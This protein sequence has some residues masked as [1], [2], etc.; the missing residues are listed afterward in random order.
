LGLPLVIGFE[1]KHIG[2]PAAEG[3]KIGVALGAERKKIIT[4]GYA[5]GYKAAVFEGINILEDVVFCSAIPESKNKG[6]YKELL[7]ELPF[8]GGI[9]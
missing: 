7:L 5:N 3:R 4:L 2:I 9:R 6:V 1:N 8:R